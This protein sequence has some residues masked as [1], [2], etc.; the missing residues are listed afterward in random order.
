MI[1]GFMIVKDVLKQGY[2][3]VEAV[4]SAL[5]ICNEFLISEGYSTDG[6]FEIVERMAK[7]NRKIK[8]YRQKW[9]SVKKA[10]VLPEV[11]NAIRKM[12]S[13][14]Y[15][16]YIQA[17]E[18]IHEESS[19]F[20][21]VLPEICPKA[22]TFSFPYLHLVGNYK[23]AEE[24][25]LRLSKNL[26]SIVPIS[27]AWALG[28]SKSFVVS[29]TFKSLGNPRR[30]LRYMHRG[31]AWTYANRGNSLFSKSICLPKPV[32]RYWSLFPS[33]FLE[34]CAMHAEMF[35]LPEFNK[36]IN[37]LKSHV[38]NPPFFWKIASELYSA[39]YEFKYPEAF[40]T[41]NRK[42]HPKLIQDFISDS[43]SNTYYVREEVLN[44]ISGL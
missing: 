11:T 10:S 37:I 13:S 30:L 42:D 27:D 43:H 32:F 21:K 7:L 24:F 44:L 15:I 26:Q 5:P 40:G 41:V 25:R 35:S 28:P 4:A 38:D 12:C 19:E 36:T 39:K 3:F 1:S 9:P 31:I 34:K 23:F 33:N 8:V 14:D 18:I 16:F 22:H 29:E 20:I 2:P 17:N 6:T